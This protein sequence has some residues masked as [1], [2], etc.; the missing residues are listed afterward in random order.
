MF[1]YVINRNERE[2]AWTYDS[3]VLVTKQKLS[4]ETESKLQRAFRKWCEEMPDDSCLEED[5]ELFCDQ[6]TIEELYGKDIWQYRG[7]DEY[8]FK[9]ETGRIYY[10]TLKRDVIE[11][12]MSG[13]GIEYEF[14]YAEW[15]DEFYA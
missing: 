3:Y 4:E 7:D 10:Y 2:D 9:C 11:P 15:H 13:L 6:D 8:P 1:T 14:I 12:V 5:E